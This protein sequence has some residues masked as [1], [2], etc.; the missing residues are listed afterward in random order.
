MFIFFSDYRFDPIS[1]DLYY[2]NKPGD[3]EVGEETNEN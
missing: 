1:L 3:A 2:T